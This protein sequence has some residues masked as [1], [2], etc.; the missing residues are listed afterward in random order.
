MLHQKFS[1]VQ[2]PDAAQLEKVAFDHTTFVT[3]LANHSKELNRQTNRKVVGKHANGQPQHA[4]GLLHKISFIFDAISAR[5]PPMFQA[6]V[7][8]ST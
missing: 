4:N 2:R 5:T 1:K 7:A 8:S 3:R 6:V